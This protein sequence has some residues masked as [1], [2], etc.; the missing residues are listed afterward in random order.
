MRSVFNSDVLIFVY[1]KFVLTLQVSTKPSFYP[2][3]S[4]KTL[5]KRVCSCEIAPSCNLLPMDENF[6]Q[7]ILKFHNQIRDMQTQ[8]SPS[9]SG[10]AVL[11]YDSELEEVSTCWTVKCRNEYSECFVTTKYTETTQSV[12]QLVL[13]K[14]QTPNIF[15]WLQAMED[16]VDM[17]AS[18]ALRIIE[19]LPT[20]VESEH[21]NNYAQLMTD[22]VLSIGCSWSINDASNVLNLVCTYGPRGPLQGEPIFKIGNPCSS[23]P[24]GYSC[25]QIDSFSLLCKFVGHRVVISVNQSDDSWKFSTNSGPL[26]TEFLSNQTPKLQ[27]AEKQQTQP[28]DDL[29]ESIE[30]IYADLALP[31]TSLSAEET[32]PPETRAEEQDPWDYM[33]SANEISYLSCILITTFVQFIIIVVV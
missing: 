10:L 11:H 4:T 19:K 30:D 8:R 5:C 28:I 26:T 12:T 9:P 27:R 33:S 3:C 17:V 18:D 16:W 7:S 14:G 31:E 21:L 25:D 15:M 29:T 22:R 2:Y 1:L 6:R 20:G 24:H 23:C 13:E 32:A